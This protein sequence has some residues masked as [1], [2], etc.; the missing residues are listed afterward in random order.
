VPRRASSPSVA[1][2]RHQAPP[3]LKCV[4][5]AYVRRTRPAT[6]V[7]SAIQDVCAIVELFV[8][9]RGCSALNESPCEGRLG[10]VG[11]FRAAREVEIGYT[12]LVGSVPW[13]YGPKLRVSR[14][15][16]ERRWLAHFSRFGE[17]E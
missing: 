13:K 4:F 7:D 2:F 15:A 12:T 16:A 1:C 17:T 11:R 9:S 3:P 8:Q 10:G 14:G 5:Y 6:V